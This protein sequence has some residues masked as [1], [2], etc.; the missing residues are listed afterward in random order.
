MA[1]AAMIRMIATTIS[2]SISEKPRELFFIHPP[3]QTQLPSIHATYNM[4]LFL[5]RQQSGAFFH[6]GQPSCIQILSV[7]I[8][9]PSRFCALRHILLPLFV[10][11]ARR[12]LSLQWYL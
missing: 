10:Q 1:I 5:P 8:E 9:N 6:H 3:S 12:I 2:N 4:A 7:A 11:T